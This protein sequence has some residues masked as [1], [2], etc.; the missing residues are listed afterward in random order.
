MIERVARRF[1]LGRL[2]AEPVRVPGGLSNELWRLVTEDG[3]FAV[4]R[5]VVN[6]DLPGFVENVEA[7]FEIERRAWAAGVA[8]PEPV[9]DPSTGRVL[10][11]VDGSLFRVHRWIDGRPGT[12]SVVA[13][14]RLLASIHAVGNPRWE[15]APDTRWI[16]DRWGE[17]LVVLAQ[18]VGS[19]PEL[20]VVVD[21]H[22]DL[23]RKNTLLSGDG[24][25]MAVD[26]DA[27]GPVSAVHEAVGL[28]LDWCDTDV[29]VF[30]EA[31]RVYGGCGGVA[32]PAQP[33]V[34]AGWVAAQGGWLD[35]NAARRSETV[36]GQAEVTATL[37][38]LR[39]LAEGLDGLLAA[40]STSVDA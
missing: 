15:P 23:D 5:M 9:E 3:S 40:L 24:V 13:A 1:K 17:D 38:R 35:Y 33:W 11:A 21:S 36:L 27:A 39:M 26:W 18:R 14:A 30:V 37:A 31:V 25:M 16:A 28:A 34:F 8:M 2:V 22:R 6:A 4:K 12:G 7:A 19:M 32:V 29:A 20:A 10:A